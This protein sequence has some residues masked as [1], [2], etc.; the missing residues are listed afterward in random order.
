[1][2]YTTLLPDLGPCAAPSHKQ[3]FFQGPPSENRILQCALES[4]HVF[5]VVDIH[6]AQ[7]PQRIFQL[8]LTTGQGRNLLRASSCSW[9]TA[10]LSARNS[11]ATSVFSSFI[12]TT[13]TFLL[14]G[15]VR[16]TS[17]Y[18][19]VVFCVHPGCRNLVDLPLHDAWRSNTMSCFA[20]N[21]C[22]NIFSECKCAVFC[23]SSMNRSHMFSRFPST[24][25]QGY[26]LDNKMPRPS[27]SGPLISFQ[28]VPFHT[29][30]SRA[31]FVPSLHFTS[32]ACCQQ[33]SPTAS[34]RPAPATVADPRHCHSKH[35]Q[36]PLPSPNPLSYLR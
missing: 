13:S 31:A 15:P 23:A 6:F 32:P 26:Q 8:L 21:L 10:P 29:R 24:V 25:L 11:R 7:R 5:A 12:S 16:R 3:R 19:S 34:S 36:G 33:H 17:S 28:E 27:M 20:A 4:H 9:K 22:Q 18:R 14:V 2:A 30:C 1:M 35:V